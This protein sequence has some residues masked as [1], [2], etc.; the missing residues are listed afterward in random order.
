MDLIVTVK[1]GFETRYLYIHHFVTSF[2]VAIE[3]YNSGV[4]YFLEC[5]CEYYLIVE[6]IFRGYLNIMRTYSM[7]N[8]I[9]TAII[10]L[11]F[12][13]LFDA[14]L[15]QVDFFN[16]R[17][18]FYDKQRKL[19]CNWERLRRHLI[20]KL[21]YSEADAI[22]I[23][24]DI[25]NILSSCN[26]YDNLTS[27]VIRFQNRDVLKIL[28]SCAENKIMLVRRL[29]EGQSEL[30]MYPAFINEILV[31]SLDNK[32]RILLLKN[33]SPLL[34][35]TVLHQ[36]AWFNASDAIA[37]I[38]GLIGEKNRKEIIEI[39]NICGETALHIACK[40][41]HHQ[42]LE[43]LLCA[44]DS[45]A[46]R[47]ILLLSEDSNKYTPI[48]YAVYPIQDVA[49]DPRD[50]PEIMKIVKVIQ[51]S[52]EIT[53]I[54]KLLEKPPATEFLSSFGQQLQKECRVQTERFIIDQKLISLVNS[55]SEDEEAIRVI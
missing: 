54:V 33:Q 17:I 11:Y 28:L 40:R 19:R 1:T 10:I 16:C 53:H 41:G 55:V 45:K 12:L 5:L 4:A 6:K 3:A 20:S 24:R 38:L 23:G 50:K 8:V 39:K 32:D 27:Y 21:H 44:I 43:S 7:V 35:N 37:I 30:G 47:F 52:I 36:A 49:G 15:P 25:E 26:S 2:Y 34:G 51:E 9:T 22:R 48:H 46:D 29:F 18:F 31:K 42:A 14:D 13:W